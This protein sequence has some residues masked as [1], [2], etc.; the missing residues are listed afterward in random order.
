MSLDSNQLS[1]TIPAGFL[2][3]KYLYTFNVSDNV[4]SGNATEFV[5]S[6]GDQS[7]V[8]NC[9]DPVVPPASPRC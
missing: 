1:G 3:F 2:A 5:N 6:F 9:F 4:L 8:Y 7:F